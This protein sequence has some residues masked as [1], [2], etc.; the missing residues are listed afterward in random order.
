MELQ[1]QNLLNGLTIGAFYALVA[2][3]YTMVYGVLKLINFAHGDLFMWGAYLGLG[4]LNLLAFAGLA[5]SPFALVPAIIMVMA[6]AGLAGVL[7]ERIAYRPLRG[8]G[9]L[10]PVISAL[11]VAFILALFHNH[12]GVGVIF[13]TQGQKLSASTATRSPRAMPFARSTLA[14]R[15][16]VS[17]SQP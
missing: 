6:T 4:A 7:L 14:S 10:P 17:R 8:A 12:Q 9:R 11:G 16:E 15:F 13:H 3:G 5:I 2:L 1:A